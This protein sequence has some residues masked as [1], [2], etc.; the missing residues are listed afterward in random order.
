MRGTERA[1]AD[2]A[3]PSAAWAT[4]EGPTEADLETK[5]TD[6][7]QDDGVDRYYPGGP[8]REAGIKH[9]K[10]RGAFYCKLWILGKY[11]VGPAR[12]SFEAAREDKTIVARVLQHGTQAAV[13]GHISLDPREHAGGAIGSELSGQP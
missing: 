12:Y 8:A 1:G 3:A 11:R 6:L 10:R 7:L 13:G 4:D 9:D 2:G 5:V